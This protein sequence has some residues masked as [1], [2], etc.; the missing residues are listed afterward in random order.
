MRSRQDLNKNGF[1]LVE[2]LIAL[3]ISAMVL[4]S[5]FLFAF[6]ALGTQKRALTFSSNFQEALSTLGLMTK[7]IRASNLISPSSTDKKLLLFSGPDL[8]T[9]E[10][11]SGK[12]KR[13][14]NASGQYITADGSLE[15]AAFFYP[16]PKSVRIEICP[17]N[18]TLT[19]TAETYCR[20]T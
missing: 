19:M 15:K 11:L 12:I 8:I 4:N 6:G 14:R 5:A 3:I 18:T 1:T 16:S 10:F 20:N 17:A 7:E 9:Y 2:L 13:S